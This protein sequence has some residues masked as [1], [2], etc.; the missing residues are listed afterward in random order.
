MTRAAL[1]ASIG[2]TNSFVQKAFERGYMQIAAAELLCKIHGFDIDKLC[3]KPKEPDKPK[4]L[5]SD[6]KTLQALVETLMRIE[7][8]VDR[9]YQELF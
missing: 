9:I 2:R 4:V 8:K 7:K 1:S 5:M 6:D 3:P